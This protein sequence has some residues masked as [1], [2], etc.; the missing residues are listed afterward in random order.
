M[1]WLLRKVFGVIALVWLLGWL[2]FLVSVFIS[3]NAAMPMFFVMGIASYAGIP[4]CIIWAILKIISVIGKQRMRQPITVLGM[5]PSNQTPHNGFL[6]LETPV[7]AR[8]PSN[9]PSSSST[10][11]KPEVYTY[12]APGMPMCPKCGQRPAVF[13]CST[14]QRPVCLECVAKH[15]EPEKCSYVPA[16]RA[17]MPR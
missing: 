15:D 2:L 8:G 7:P 9:A 16:F 12:S 5:Y 4:S 10:P 1:L 14:H 3:P 6:R 13:Y 11:S 17:R